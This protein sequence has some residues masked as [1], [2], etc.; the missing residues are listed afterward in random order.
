MVKSCSAISPRFSEVSG[1]FLVHRRFVKGAR[2]SPPCVRGAA[3]RAKRGRR[4]P[5]F[6]GSD[7]E[8]P[9]PFRHAN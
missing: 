6:W 3:D 9:R 5:A 4:H 2:P 1:P 7:A 8:N